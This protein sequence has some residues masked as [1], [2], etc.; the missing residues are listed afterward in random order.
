MFRSERR[1]GRTLL[2]AIAAISSL[3]IPHGSRCQ[4]L[5]RLIHHKELRITH[6]G[7]GDG[8]H[9]LLS[10]TEGAPFRVGTRLQDRKQIKELFRD[11]GI[12]VPGPLLAPTIKLS[13]TSL[14]SRKIM[15]SSGTNPI[16]ILIL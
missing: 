13:R 5:C 2:S 7:S 12:I 10:T 16:P 1:M 4:A 11:P 8:E 6:Q 9:L 3:N 15:R 14:R